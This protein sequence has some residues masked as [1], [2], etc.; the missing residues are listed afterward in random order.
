MPVLDTTAYAKLVEMVSINMEPH[1]DQ[2]YYFAN[3]TAGTEGVDPIT[4]SITWNGS[5]W[6][7]LPFESTGWKKGGEK[8]ERPKLNLPDFSG[9]F[10][11]V[12]KTY[13]HGIGAEIKR[14]QV[15]DPLNNGG[16]LLSEEVYQLA[17]YTSTGFT[18]S[19]ELAT[20]MD[21]TDAKI[22]GFKMLRKDYP[23]LGS[24]LLR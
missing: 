20:A 24:Q 12:L 14:Y 1:G 22:L 13:R 19:L 8:P 11:D 3:S 18:L 23:G 4:D 7:P 21:I 15:L 2:I 6:L 5:S 9:Q 17:G 10:R 16:I